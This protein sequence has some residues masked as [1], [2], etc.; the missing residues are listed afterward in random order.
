MNAALL[1]IAFCGVFLA[2]SLPIFLWLRALELGYAFP[3]FMESHYLTIATF[4]V[5]DTQMP[6]EA[7][8]DYDVPFKAVIRKLCFC[9][10]S[11]EYDNGIRVWVCSASGTHL[12]IQRR[13]CVPLLKGADS[14]NLN[15]RDLLHP[16]C[17]A[18]VTF[19]EGG[20]L[21]AL[22]KVQ[23]EDYWVISDPLPIFDNLII[24]PFETDLLLNWSLSVDGEVG[25]ELSY[26]IHWNVADPDHRRI[27]E[28]LSSCQSIVLHFLE[29]RSLAPIGA[30][31]LELYQPYIQ[32]IV[33]Q[34]IALTAALPTDENA[35]RE[36]L[37]SFSLGREASML[38]SMEKLG[39]CPQ[40]IGFMLDSSSTSFEKAT[41]FSEHIKHC[42]ACQRAQP[43]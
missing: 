12:E 3:S 5:Q 2:V 41:E 35:R 4:R 10:S 39:L 7:T 11:V 37:E 23:P 17:T 32:S 43:S 1:V 8:I 13:N 27:V 21:I 31:V 20:Y 24:E 6:N 9:G 22:L 42:S 16:D 38:S 34:A 26:T 36:K 33:A 19:G 14:G 28:S 18:V 25:R 30:A 15:V 29:A 40:M